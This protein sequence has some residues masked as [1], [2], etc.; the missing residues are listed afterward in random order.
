MRLILLVVSFLVLAPC[1]LVIAQTTGCN[2]ATACNYT[3]GGFDVNSGCEYPGNACDDN[4]ATT[5]S[6]VWSQTSSSD[7]DCVNVISGCMDNSACNYN[8]IATIQSSCDYPTGHA[9]NTAAGCLECSQT[10]GDP[11]SGWG[12]GLGYLIDNDLNN[13][14]ICDD[15]DMLGC[16]DSNA[17][18]YDMHATSESLFDDGSDPCVSVDPENT[19]NDFMGLLDDDNQPYR[20]K[21]AS[22]VN[23]YR[24]YR[25]TSDWDEDG[26]TD[27]FGSAQTSAFVPGSGENWGIADTDTV[28]V[29]FSTE[30]GLPLTGSGYGLVRHPAY[31]LIQGDTD[32]NGTS[33]YMEIEGCMDVTACN[34]DSLATQQPADEWLVDEEE[35]DRVCVTP[36][37]CGCEI[38]GQQVSHPLSSTDPLYSDATR[39]VDA[40]GVAWDIATGECDCDGNVADAL[41][42]CGGSCFADDLPV[43]GNGICDSDDVEG[44]MNEDACNF[45]IANTYQNGT[46]IARCNFPSDECGCLFTGIEGNDSLTY[47]KPVLSD[48]VAAVLESGFV[49]DSICDCRGAVADA[50][51]ICRIVHPLIQ[52]GNAPQDPDFCFADSNGNGVCDDL[53]I[54]GCTDNTACNFQGATLEDNS[55]RY[56]N[57]CGE[58]L[59]VGESSSIVGCDCAGNELDICGV[60]A[61]PGQTKWY[62]D[63]DSDGFG[64]ASVSV[65]DCPNAD[66]TGALNYPGYIKNAADCDDTDSSLGAP[67]EC[68]VCGGSGGGYDYG[69]TCGC[70]PWG[71]F[72][73]DGSCGCTE[74][75]PFIKIYPSP[76]RDC[77]GDCVNGSDEDGL[78]II[79]SA[80][81]VTAQPEVYSRIQTGGK[82]ITN[83]DVFAME[84]WMA[85]IDTLHSRMSKNLDD[86]SY[87]GY[88]DTLTIEKAIINNGTLNSRGEARIGGDYIVVPDPAA[89]PLVD[90]V[91]FF[92]D[93]VT[94]EWDIPIYT[95][96]TNADGDT[97]FDDEG[98]PKTTQL[99]ETPS[100]YKDSV[101]INSNLFVGGRLRVKGS[102]FSDGGINTTSLKME[103]DLTV[104]GSLTV[105]GESDQWGNAIMQDSLWVRKGAL[106]VGQLNNVI[107]DTTGHI[108]ASDLVLTDSLHVA[109]EATIGGA[110]ILSDG[111]IVNTKQSDLQRPSLKVHVDGTN[112]ITTINSLLNVNG[113][114]TLSNG[115]TV[116]G[117]NSKFEGT[118]TFNAQ[119][120]MNENVDIAKK[121]EVGG[122]T[123]L[124]SLNVANIAH[125]GNKL[126]VGGPAKGTSGYQQYGLGL[127]TAQSS[128]NWPEQEGQDD[129]NGNRYSGRPYQMVVDASGAGNAGYNGVLIRLAIDEQYEDFQNG[130]NFVTFQRWPSNKVAGR[131]EGET[132]NE[133]WNN[134]GYSADRRAID[135]DIAFAAT[136]VVSAIGDVT[137]EWM[138]LTSDLAESTATLWPAAGWPSWDIAQ[139]VVAIIRG[140][141]I[142]SYGVPKAIWDLA[143]TYAEY[144][145]TVMTFDDWHGDV[146]NAIGVTY[147][148]GA[149]DYAEW[150]EKENTRVDF[151]PGEVVGVRAGLVSYDT[152]HSDH[153]LVISTKPMMLGNEIKGNMSDYEKVA[154]M[155]QVPIRVQGV[156]NQGDYILP[157]GENNGYARAVA[158]DEIGF[159]EI[160]NI[161][162]IAWEGGA[163]KYFNTVNCSVGL[164][165]QGS[166]QLVDIVQAELL[167]IRQSI[168]NEIALTVVESGFVNQRRARRLKKKNEMRILKQPTLLEKPLIQVENEDFSNPNIEGAIMES[169]QD[170][171]PLE[172]ALEIEKLVNTKI[173]KLESELKKLQESGNVEIG[174]KEMAEV[175]KAI[176]AQWAAD[177]PGFESAIK[178]GRIMVDPK[179]APAIQAY[180][181]VN[182]AVAVILFEN[183]ASTEKLQLVLREALVDVASK[184]DSDLL[185][186][187]PPGSRAEA[188]LVEDMRSQLRQAMREYYPEAFK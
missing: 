3:T 15:I 48:Y 14:N 80:R 110:A 181:E 156:V 47:T 83:T 131:I 90:S 100:Q 177:R 53:E 188:Q 175:T 183:G 88:S 11:S 165:R 121:L 95:V 167:D 44:C 173:Q 151:L 21:L 120:N 73:E 13:N 162:G 135:R 46:D 108:A 59:A 23:T 152:E 149:G 19:T 139:T 39:P 129:A 93:P 104:G 12:A 65:T 25:D 146:V 18:N 159:D 79:I 125:L 35:W 77:N 89:A 91:Y 72:E 155:G 171:L 36:G 119:V 40:N 97:I 117:G 42:N 52:N 27:E 34:Y 81:E 187:Y 20:L 57:Q 122:T 102:T 56:K 124:N 123:D 60:C 153:N 161:V 51:G 92:Q 147:A 172:T 17:G 37:D 138:D 33:D 126:F 49:I 64:N 26:N 114:T 143:Q 105:K 86:G 174:G 67:D 107:I 55:C 71:S 78:C 30:T 24:V 75:A 132:V 141:M 6:S 169:V 176:K 101:S 70:E 98:N 103:G 148:S 164:D 31:V 157:S 185:K 29:R 158:R 5:F 113:E 63:L 85:N 134:G 160:P 66:G 9:N 69:V 182:A 163:D 28:R 115:L 186:A 179:F 22:V 2:D 1:S 111:L 109:G 10:I 106:T 32:E 130:N 74:T 170:G 58:C 87:G 116:S 96:D 38:G 127:T 154:F 137:L 136:S 144:L 168:S 112:A 62:Q 16:M 118:S 140:T 45:N 145:S 54:E 184:T 7:C 50:I 133:L 178:E 61:G 68:G 41:S 142:G 4:D 82:A 84:R 99:E 94:G 43:G 8:S 166:A 150:I 76:G 128:P 180:E